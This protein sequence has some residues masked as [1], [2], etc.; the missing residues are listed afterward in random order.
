MPR[1]RL[2]GMSHCMDR[3]FF[4]FSAERLSE[5]VA[6]DGAGRV[7]TTRVISPGDDSG[8]RFVD[9]T[10]IPPGSSVG[11]HTHGQEDEEVYVI[12]SGRGRMR[13]ESRE[14]EVGPGD[15]IMNAPGGTHGLV[16]IGPEPLRMVV[17]DVSAPAGRNGS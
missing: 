14:F 10:E 2:A 16:N 1:A 8:F 6:H 5:V 4:S 17:L 13:L 15:V 7:R 12:V 3:R 11:V 9:L